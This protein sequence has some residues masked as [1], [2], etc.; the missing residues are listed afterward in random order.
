MKKNTMK[1][2]AYVL[3]SLIVLIMSLKV[4]AVTEEELKNK[5]SEIEQQ[6]ENA[7]T[8]IAGIKEEMTAS[9]EQINRLNVQIKECEDNLAITTEKLDELNVE[10]EDR[11][12]E[13]EEAQAEYDKQKEILDKRLIAIYESSRTT[14]LDIL[15]GSTSLSDFLTKYYMLEELAEYDNQLLRSLDS[16]QIAVGIKS[17][18]VENKRNEVQNTK[19]TIEAKTGAMEVLIS[20]KHH[21]IENLSQEEIELNQQLEQ[22]EIDKKEIEKELVELA[23]QNAIAKSITPSKSGYISPLIGKTK[24]NITTGYNGYAGHTG[25]DFA[26]PLG[27][28]VVAVKDGTVVISDAIKNSNGTYRS[29]GEYVVIDHHDGTMTLYA[30][31]TPGS[32]VVQVNDE[33]K[34]RRAS[35]E[36]WFNRKFNWTAF[37][38]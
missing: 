14:Y 29:Y 9:L 12:Q 1:I 19:D 6:I 17:S 37:A 35:D 28:D 13:L 11:K 7:H 34:Q 20:D 32:R 27:S 38:F 10:L 25:V 26:T 16:Y 15:V 22:F 8:E 3:I 21:L 36:I 31:G 23:R 5:Q 18:L 2:I 30:H 4:Y 33:V 24:A